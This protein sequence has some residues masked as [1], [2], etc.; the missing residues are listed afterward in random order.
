MKTVV[1]TGS[2]RGI[3][4]GLAEAFLRAGCSVVVNGRSAHSVQRATQDL[5]RQFPPPH[6]FGIPGDVTDIIQVQNIWDTAVAHFGSIDIWI[7]NAGLENKPAL[8]WEVPPDTLQAV[9]DTNVIGVMYCCQVAIRG[10]IAQR[11]GQ[12]Y[13]MAGMGS[14]G[15]LPP[16][17]TP[18]GTSKYALTF[19]TKALV[20]ET[21]HLPLQIST[22]NP[23]MV[24]TDML[25]ANIPPERENQAKRFF[26][27]MADNVETVAPWLAGQMLANQKSG[28]HIAWLTT[29]K[30]IGRVLLAPFR[31]R[32]LF[33]N[34]LTTNTA[35]NK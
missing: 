25:I 32:D 23:G 1:I 16:N 13:N 5:A 10:M 8:L 35:N 33:S 20:K 3:G 22:I 9:I 24:I 19:L 14:E 21:E 18:Y 27:I 28:A 17:L 12:I 11:Q 31:K 15:R 4:Y 2:T 26:N 7:N 30:M 6:I 29:P 34:E